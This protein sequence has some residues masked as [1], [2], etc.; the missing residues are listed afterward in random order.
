MK[1]LSLLALTACLMAGVAQAQTAA[2]PAEPAPATA[3]ATDAAVP[4][5]EKPKNDDKPR[6][7][8]A[9]CIRNTGSRVRPRDAKT[10]CNGQPGRAYTRDDLDRTGQTGLAEALRTLDPSIR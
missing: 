4:A 1:P 2:P 6:L 9:Q 5:S 8:D 3:P 7:S 10:P